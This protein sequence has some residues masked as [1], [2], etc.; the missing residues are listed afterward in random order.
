VGLGTNFF[1]SGLAATGNT[2]T[3]LKAIHDA[4]WSTPD[5]VFHI[6]LTSLPTVFDPSATYAAFG[7]E[8]DPQLCR[9]VR[10]NLGDLRIC[11]LR[12]VRQGPPPATLPGLPPAP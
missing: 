4:M 11:H 6:A 7:F 3:T 1:F 9:S 10:S 5:Q 8:F 2:P 12:S